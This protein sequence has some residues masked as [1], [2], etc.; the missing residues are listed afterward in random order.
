M[1]TLP[2]YSF[3]LE[4]LTEC[5]KDRKSVRV[6]D[7]GCGDGRLVGFLMDNGYDAYGVDV[8]TFFDDFYSHTD[9]TLLTQKRIS[10]I[11][12]DGSGDFSGRTF[13]F[14]ISHM[15]IEHI[16]DKVRHFKAMS[17]YMNHESIV[18]LLYPVFESIREGHVRQF[19]IHWIPKGTLRRAASYFQKA[20]RIPPDSMGQANIRDYVREKIGAV[21]ASCF[22]ETSH[23]IDRYLR[24]SFVFFHI[25]NDYFIFRAKQK[26]LFVLAAVLRLIDKT[27]ICSL[28][29]RLYTGAVV[30]AS[31]K[32]RT[33]SL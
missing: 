32:S 13:D 29:F 5:F 33:D 19:F 22:Y 1:E 11:D 12:K 7:Y 21:D 15:V 3:V 6:L 10:V 30:T 28:V 17:R 16:D 4:K 8:D 9:Q 14:I 26:R 18:L 31:L 25:E 20:L 24:E 23:A 27:G 2:Y